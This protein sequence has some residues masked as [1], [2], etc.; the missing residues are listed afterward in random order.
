MTITPKE[1]L[2]EDLYKRLHDTWEATPGNPFLEIPYGYIDIAKILG[3]EIAA[4]I[5]FEIANAIIAKA[6]SMSKGFINWRER[7]EDL[8]NAVLGL[9]PEKRGDPKQ[10]KW[11]DIQGL[12]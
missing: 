5:E 3:A 1:K 9:P 4:E 10:F 11:S 6:S 2:V 8:A 12:T 7:E